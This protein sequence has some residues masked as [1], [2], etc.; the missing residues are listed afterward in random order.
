[1][2]KPHSF[3]VTIRNQP[4]TSLK[5]AKIR[6]VTLQD[7]MRVVALTQSFFPD[8]DRAVFEE[9]IVPF[10]KDSQ[11]SVIFLLGGI[12]HDEAFRNLVE[13]EDQFLH[14]AAPAPEILAAKEAGI[15][16]EEQVLA[17]GKS[18]GDFIKSLA[19]A[20]N[21]RVIYIPTATAPSMPTEVEIM[22]FIHHKKAQIDAFAEK[23][24]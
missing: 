7:G 5:E 9:M 14:K 1:M 2:K 16:F 6:P 19:D 21:A 4:K 3:E 24:P 20:G 18:C 10:L 22:R 23:H 8:H 11:P 17:L 13:D 15:H 12:I